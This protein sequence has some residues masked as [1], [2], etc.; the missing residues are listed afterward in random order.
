MGGNALKEITTRRV[1]REE[2]IKI[3]DYVIEKIS[4]GIANHSFVNRRILDIPAYRTKE[5]FGDLDIL[6]ETFSGESLNYA[7]MIHGWFSPKQLVTNS[8]VYSFDYENFQIDLILTPT[9]YY[10]TSLSYYSWNDLGNLAGRIFKKLG[11]K[12]GHKGLSYI[13][14][15]KDNQFNSFAEIV[16]SKDIKKII[17]FGDLNYEE[18]IVGFDTVEQM[19]RWVSKSKYFHKDIYLL[20]N[21]NHISRTRDKKRKIYNEFRTWCE[22]A[23]GLPEYP[24]TEMREQDG[25]AGK[26][27]FLQLALKTFDGFDIQHCKILSQ[28]ENLLRVKQNFNGEIVSRITGLQGKELGVFMQHFVNSIGGKSELIRNFLHATT[29]GIEIQIKNEYAKF[30]T[31]Q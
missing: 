31:L 15:D 10:D 19:F 2:Y 21:R 9:E 27:E 22:T 20:H 17:E 25:Y 1:D 11:F 6:L 23:Q 8:G 30:R 26:P 3:R 4:S 16:V 7:D 14:R 29:S 18:F 13:F 12:Y 28:H 5:S 24:W